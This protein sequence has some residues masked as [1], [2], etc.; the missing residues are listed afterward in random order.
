MKILFLQDY[1]R[2]TH[3]HNSQNGQY[4]DYKRTDMGKK[5]TSLLNDIGLT[6]R[7]YMIDYDYDLIPEPQKVNN[8]TGKVIKYKEPVLKLRKEPEKRL[9]K[10][11]MKTKPDIIIPM[12]GMG[13]KNL[14][15]S[16]SITK[17][18]GVPVQKTITDEETGEFFDTWILPMFSM[19]Y[20][21]MNPN[22]ENLVKAD[23][24]TLSRFIAEGAQA[25]E[26]KKVEYELVMTIERVKQIFE[27]LS[28]FKPLTAWDLETNSLR[29]DV[30]GAKPLVMSLSWEEGQGVTI[31]LEHHESPWNE[32]ELAIVYNHLQAFVA[33][34]Q[35]PKVGHNIQFDIRF[36]MNTKGFAYFENNRDTL[37]GYYLIVAQK[38]ESSKRLSDLAYE[39]TDMGGYDNPL[40]DYKKKYKEDYI[41]RKKAEIDE[42]KVSE[43]ERVEK[44]YKLAQAKYKEEVAKAKKLGKS[45]KS[46]LK[47]VKEKVVVPSKTEV[48]TVNEIDGG[49]FN[50][51]WIPLEIMHPYASGD[52]DCCLRI[53]NVL[54]QRIAPHEKILALWTDFYPKLTRTLAHLEAEGIFVD[55]EYA[56]VLEK[57]YAEEEER[58]IEELRKFP[59]VQELEAEHMALY[60]AGLE[61]WKKPKA[62]RDTE[63]AKLRDKYK[64]SDKENKVKFNPGSAV[65]KGKVLYKIL[66]LTLPY[67]KESIKEKPFDN[68]VPENELTWEDY[69]TDKHALGYIAEHDEDAK[70]LAEMLLEYSKVNTLKNNFAQKLP[71][72][73]SNKD[74]KVHGSFK[75]TGTETSRLSSKEPNMQQ[76]PSKVG[77][78]KR[79]DYTYPIKRMFKTS[80]ENGALLQLDYS[81]LE[82]RILALVA[83]D[84]AMTQA[85]LDGEDLHKSTASIVW[86]VPVSEVSKDM[87]KNAKSVNFGIAYGETPFSIA[88]KLGVTPEEAERIFEDYF[89]NKPRIKSFIDETHEFVKKNGYVDTLQGHRR[90]IRDAFSKD[91]NTFNG[92]LRKSVNTIIQG[93]GAYLT[94]MSLIYIDDYL[95]T[96]GMKS[97]IAITVHD[98]IVI[99]C[100]RE[101][102]DEVA[103]VA[104]F[105]MENLPI[106]FLTINWKG[107]QMR[108]PIV[109]DVEIGENYNDM[110]DYDAEE[111]N[112]FAS[113]KGY[114][115]Y[116][117][118]Q[119]K[120][121]DYKNAGMIS[122]EQMEAGINAV[123]A[124]IEQYK[125]I[126]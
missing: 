125:L 18:R 94:N 28:R 21:A 48:K 51:D 90:L 40:E 121:E 52:T 26:P 79:F 76:V 116:Y 54:Y 29:G 82:M 36:L 13:C 88:P 89:A 83:G 24:S 107:E 42:L 47:P 8:K 25:F 78:P 65:H 34:A 55:K 67:D 104:C 124:S 91:R 19:E 102:V 11:L 4:V 46:I 10:R 49:D 114:V 71:L 38:I 87:R 22:I 93:T 75:I 39:L 57:V 43:Q 33:D 109:A 84:E 14:L 103:K 100:P 70:E 86:K 101:E 97:R 30:L 68:G 44:A 16:T 96:K 66:G 61:E 112:K 41:A 92:A 119:A 53:Y 6:G 27:F 95:R 118:D 111:V 32:E 117:K 35:Q 105:I 108:F 17:A 45:T 126:A 115:K 73:A 58:L 56:K 63:V 110:V 77:D 62:E 85:F 23:I 120:F 50:Y 12:G 99:D 72:L 9:L 98:S 5:L 81:A 31:P 37:I 122:E 1:I 74:G 106:D 123:K 59:A 2:E 20:L 64:I 60:K 3:V 15:N 80:F 69:K 7:D 113:Y